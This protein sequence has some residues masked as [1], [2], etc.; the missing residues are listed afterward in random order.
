MTEFMDTFAFIA[1]HDARDSAHRSVLEYF[2]D[3]DGRILTTEWILL[4]VLD[5]FTHPDFRI[6]VA[7]S[8]EQVRNDP[9]FEVI[10][11]DPVVYRA[12]LDLF[13]KRQDKHWS[14]TDCTSFVVMEQHK[15]TDALT[16]D[17]HF[18]QAGF[19]PIFEKVS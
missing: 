16:A 2:D 11:F 6:T 3:Y 8:L 4:E 5:S 14:L 9:M 18:R 1:W 17:H 19:H 12:S 13:T 10:P 7:A 15:L